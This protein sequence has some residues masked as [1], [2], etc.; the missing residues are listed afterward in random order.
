LLCRLLRVITP[1]RQRLQSASHKALQIFPS[2]RMY[3]GVAGDLQVRPCATKGFEQGASRS[4]VRAGCL[5]LSGSSRVPR[6]P[7]R[8]AIGLPQIIGSHRDPIAIVQG[9]AVHDG[10]VGAPIRLLTA[11]DRICVQSHCDPSQIGSRF[12][13]SD[14]SDRTIDLIGSLQDIW[15]GSDRL[16]LL[17]LDRI[18]PPK[19]ARKWHHSFRA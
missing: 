15:I 14:P 17:R 19:P 9:S 16:F 8:Y 7:I 18:E 6:D 2:C 12:E 4:A 10:S 3:S 5:A 11:L 1:D 13:R